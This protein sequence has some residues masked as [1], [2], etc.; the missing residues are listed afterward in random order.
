M[1]SY[2]K[3]KVAGSVT[4]T[5]VELARANEIHVSI[6]GSSKRLSK[7]FVTYFVLDRQDYNTSYKDTLLYQFTQ[8]LYL[9]RIHSIL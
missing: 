1:F 2:G 5:S 8:L 9:F 3:R 7:E 6:Y 4:S